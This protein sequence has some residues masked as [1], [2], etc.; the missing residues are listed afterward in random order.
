MET[1]KD[2]FMK[3]IV[4]ICISIFHILFT[5]ILLVSPYIYDTKS[6]L[7]ALIII[8]TI[9]FILWNIFDEC[10]LTQFEN[11]NTTMITFISSV[12]TTKIKDIIFEVIM[13]INLI[14]CAY[15]LWDPFTEKVPGAPPLYS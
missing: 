12:L 9:L 2:N 7:F 11:S 10:I 14:V 1:S 15:K 3:P 13:G 8:Y 5:L 6:H 4:G